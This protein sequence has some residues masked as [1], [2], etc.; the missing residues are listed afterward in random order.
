MVGSLYPS[1]DGI[2]DSESGQTSV[3]A[4]VT[5]DSRLDSVDNIEQDEEEPISICCLQGCLTACTLACLFF[6]VLPAG[7][8]VTVYS[9]SNNDTELMVAG[10]VLMVLPIIALPVVI[11]ILFNRRRI[12]KLR[13][14]KVATTPEHKAR[15]LK[16]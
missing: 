11:T 4:Q 9:S 10:I 7:I 3:G 13:K 15:Q 16:Y 1:K 2:K 6:L 8:L 5:Q 12:M 14:R